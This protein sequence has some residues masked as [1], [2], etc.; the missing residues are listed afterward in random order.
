MDGSILDQLGD[1]LALKQPLACRHVRC[2][3]GQEC[4]DASALSFGCRGFR[5]GAAPEISDDQG[6][7][8]A[9]CGAAGAN[10]L[11]WRLS[12]KRLLVRTHKFFRARQTGQRDFL[13]PS[14]PETTLPA[15]NVAVLVDVAEREPGHAAPSLR[16]SATNSRT[17]IA[18]KRL[19][20]QEM[21]ADPVGAL[22]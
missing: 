16:A 7:D 5:E 2:G 8:G 21:A 19:R 10:R 9:R 3:S 4:C 22:C 6:V 14:P 15:A 11:W 17:N 20:I 12:T 1:M 18:A 13:L